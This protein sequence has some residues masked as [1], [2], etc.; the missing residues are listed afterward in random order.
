[1]SNLTS[2]V[3]L[4]LDRLQ[5]QRLIP[6]RAAATPVEIVSNLIGV[7]AQIPSAAALV[8]RVRTI[9]IRAADVL[10]AAAPSG[11]LVRT[12]L[13]RGTLHFAAAADLNWL[14]SILHHPPAIRWSRRPQR[15]LPRDGHLGYRP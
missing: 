1:M 3:G 11:P 12:W 7:Q 5:A 10:R 2:E 13:M 15:W 4:R 6:G 14:L 8:I 9:G